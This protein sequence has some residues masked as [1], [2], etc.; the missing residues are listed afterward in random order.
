MH[1]RFACA[2]PADTR[3]GQNEAQCSADRRRSGMA[4]WQA[5]RPVSKPCRPDPKRCRKRNRRTVLVRRDQT[6]RRSKQ[7]SVRREE[8]C[9]NYR[10]TSFGVGRNSAAY[11]AEWASEDM[12]RNTAIAYCA[13]GRPGKYGQV[14]FEPLRKR[15]VRVSGGEA[16]RVLRRTTRSSRRRL[17][18]A[19]PCGRP[20]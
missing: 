10:N 14:V 17:A 5:P 4:R 15:G 9:K 16:P 12:R 8:R 3:R 7:Q 19:S 6:R 18:S 11:C 2:V 13:V 20:E 1:G